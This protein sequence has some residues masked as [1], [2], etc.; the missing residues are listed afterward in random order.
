MAAPRK[1]RSVSTS[2][3][4]LPSRQL[5]LYDHLRAGEPHE[6]RA[7]RWGTSLEPGDG[8]PPL[9]PATSYRASAYK[10]ATHTCA[11]VLN[12]T[13]PQVIHNLWG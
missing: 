8:P 12:V 4:S 10:D 9:P 7:R 3:P 6:S 11:L 1:E 5:V 2:T 13:Y